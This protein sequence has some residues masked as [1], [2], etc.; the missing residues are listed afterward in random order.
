M[1][2]ASL[3]LVAPHQRFLG[4]FRQDTPLVISE[5]EEYWH[6]TV[7]PARQQMVPFY[8]H[9]AQERLGGGNSTEFDGV[10]ECRQVT[11]QSQPV[12]DPSH[13][14]IELFSRATFVQTDCR[15]LKLQNAT[16]RALHIR[17][18]PLAVWSL[19][20]SL[21]PVPGEPVL[22]RPVPLCLRLPPVVAVAGTVMSPMVNTYFAASG[23]QR[24]TTA[25]AKANQSTSG[26]TAFAVDQGISHGITPITV[27]R[28]RALATTSNPTDGLSPF[29]SSSGGS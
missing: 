27:V 19:P 10:F 13:A 20:T 25:E 1:G 16:M 23:A 6:S 4:Q 7:L 18:V 9:I 2:M 5:V 8:A 3:A 24:G 15:V 12:H 29:W 14:P 28:W 17:N 26:F 21:L 22:P 11:L